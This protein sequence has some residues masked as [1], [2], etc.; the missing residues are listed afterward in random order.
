MGCQR[1]YCYGGVNNDNGACE[2]D[3]S[4]GFLVHTCMWHEVREQGGAQSVVVNARNTLNAADPGRGKH[5]A[6]ILQA[7]GNDVTRVDDRIER[8]RQGISL[9]TL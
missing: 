4:R 7:R 6:Q 8:E 9:R 2:Q 3:P 1:Y 5:L